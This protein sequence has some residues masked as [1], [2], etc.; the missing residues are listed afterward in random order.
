VSI[1]PISSPDPVQQFA[2]TL[3]QSIDTNH[4]SQ[5]STDE[6]AS[7]LTNVLG[8]APASSGTGVARTTL[9]TLAAPPAPTVPAR[10]SVAMEGFE[11]SRLN[12]S[13]DL[14]PKYEFARWA[15]ANS[16]SPTTENLRLFVETHSDWEMRGSDGLRMKQSA[17]DIRSPGKESVWQ[18]VIR[19]VNGPGA[20]WQFVN[21]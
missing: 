17:L 15:Q 2:K 3:A 7:F 6:F 11:T 21:A 20:A 8:A 10:T 12:D 14:S 1:S 4:D 5:I 18:D 16:M 9:Q 19:D 13:T